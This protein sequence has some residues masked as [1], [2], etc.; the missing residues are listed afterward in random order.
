MRGQRMNGGRIR[1]HG[2]DPLC[3]AARPVD[4]TKGAGAG[5]DRPARQAP[6]PAEALA[7][8]WDEAESRLG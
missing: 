8:Q 7:D 3:E 1:C 5:G 4:G 2:E 6:F